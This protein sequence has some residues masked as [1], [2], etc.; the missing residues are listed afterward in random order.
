MKVE[1]IYYQLSQMYILSHTMHGTKIYSF[2]IY[3]ALGT[4]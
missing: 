1:P 2:I 3:Y 4:K